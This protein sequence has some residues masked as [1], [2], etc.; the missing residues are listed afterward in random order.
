M[1]Y[2]FMVKGA[3]CERF[4]AFIALCMTL[5]PVFQNKPGGNLAQGLVAKDGIR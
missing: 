5:N 2:R 1:F 4:Y 3:A